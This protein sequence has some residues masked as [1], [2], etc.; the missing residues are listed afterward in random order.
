MRTF[1]IAP[2]NP[3]HDAHHDW[4]VIATEEDGTE[5]TVETYATMAEAEAAKRVFEQQEMGP[6]PS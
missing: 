1:R 5:V 4:N 2:A 3:G 6:E